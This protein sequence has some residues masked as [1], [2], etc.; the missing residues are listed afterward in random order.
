MA[1]QT[2]IAWTHSTFNPWLG[3]LRVSPAC[4]RCYAA[5]IAKRAGWRDPKGLD[6]WDPHAQRKRTS[7]SYWQQPH[8]WNARARAS[9]QPHRVFCASMADI[10]DNKAPAAWRADLWQLVRATPA[11]TWLLLT[12]RPQHIATML[13][14]DWGDGWPHVW[15]GTTTENQTE[16]DRRIPHLA[17]I[18]AAIRF[19]SCEPLIGPIDLSP[20]L[21]RINWIIAGGES[22]G[23][24]RAMQ[25]EWVRSL[26]DQSR[27]AGISFFMKQIGSNRTA[28][29]GIKHLKGENP[30]EWPIDL[31][32]QEFPRERR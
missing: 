29:P 26:R 17:A 4:D 1:A 19:L 7:S 30:A 27:A 6:L 20:W 23:G 10:F 14:P 13:P 5:A 8:R 9:G 28:W 3:C 18:P 21:N 32:L 24:A 15:L 31:Q 11:L 22:S 25:P 16:A 2:G 12:K